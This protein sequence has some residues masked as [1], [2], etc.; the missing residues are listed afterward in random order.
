MAVYEWKNQTRSHH[1]KKGIDGCFRFPNDSQV[2]VCALLNQFSLHPLLFHVSYSASRSRSRRAAQ[3]LQS[4]R[5]ARH[6]A[7]PRLSSQPVPLQRLY[8][9]QA[10]RE[11]DRLRLGRTRR[12]KKLGMG[13][14]TSTHRASGGDPNFGG[15]RHVDSER[16]KEGGREGGRHQ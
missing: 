15:N 1:R 13:L 3:P 9:I 16:G 8:S 2:K 14:E 6:R 5:R 4:R 11:R 7:H 12:I 10:K